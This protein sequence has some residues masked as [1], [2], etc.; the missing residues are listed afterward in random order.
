MAAWR[1]C[2]CSAYRNSTSGRFLLAA[3]VGALARLNALP[4]A[5]ATAAFAQCCAAPAWAAAMA[6]L[7]PYPDAGAL[8]DTADRVWNELGPD[9]WRDAFAG[10]PR[11]GERKA[12]APTTNLA[13]RW[14]AQ[15]Q[16]GMRH[17]DAD[18]QAQL[19]AAQREYEARFGHIFLICATGRTASEMLDELRRRLRNDADTELHIAAAEQHRIT[20]LRLEKL[21]SS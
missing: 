15:E 7:R 5:E 9:A 20:R 14:S 13:Q 6:A 18:A 21:L 1:G 11:I 12:E 3:E 19:V 17:A 4:R 8:L 16:A 2:G 10:H